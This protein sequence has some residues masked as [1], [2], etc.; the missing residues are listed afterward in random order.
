MDEVSHK[1]LDDEGV[2]NARLDEIKQLYAH[3]VYEK[4]PVQECWN[5]TG[6]KPIQVKWED[7]NKGDKVHR[8]YMSRLV[9]KEIKL[10]K[11]DSLFAAT[12][13]S[14]ANKKLVSYAV[15]AGIGWVRAT[16]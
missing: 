6:K 3:V 5:A 8:E 10:D 9:A 4:V 15:T 14:E 7:I 11:R 2:R 1:K 16:R 12:P 13:P